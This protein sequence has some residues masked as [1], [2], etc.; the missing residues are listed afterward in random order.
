MWNFFN[1]RVLGRSSVRTK[2]QLNSLIRQLGT[3]SFSD[4]LDIVI[5]H[6]ASGD[7][8]DGTTRFNDFLRLWAQFNFPRLLV[9]IDLVQREVYG[10]LNMPAGNYEVYGAQ[11][12]NLFEDPSLIALDEYGVPFQLAKKL[13]TYLATDGDL[14]EALRRLRKLD[15]TK[16][17]LDIFEHDILLDAKRYA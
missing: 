6:F 17:Q 5:R 7:A 16:L 15:L 11:V 2:E 12:E 9:A 3:K 1:A 4:L 8:D 10:R 14:D 13:R